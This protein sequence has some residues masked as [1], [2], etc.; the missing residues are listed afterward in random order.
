MGLS[1]PVGPPVQAGGVSI[2]RSVFRKKLPDAMWHVY[3]AG[4]ADPGDGNNLTIELVYQKDDGTFVTLG[5]TGAFSGAG[6]VKRALG[7]GDVFGTAGVPTN[8]NIAVIR[9]QATKAAGVAATLW[10]WVVW[11]ELLAPRV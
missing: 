10:A 11:V 3:A 7:P 2:D 1:I 5:S 9:L 4:V 8:E 6:I